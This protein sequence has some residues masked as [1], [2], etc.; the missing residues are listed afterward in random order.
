VLEL[1]RHPLAADE[2]LPVL[3]PLVEAPTTGLAV[4]A[5]APPAALRSGA[6]VPPLDR[7]LTAPRRAGRRA[8]HEALRALTGLD[9]PPDAGRWARRLER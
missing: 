1:R 7:A 3:G 4:A 8:A 5:C 2:A 9:E 6:A